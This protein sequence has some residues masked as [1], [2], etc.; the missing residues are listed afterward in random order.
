MDSGINLI[1]E[2]F[3][4]ASEGIIISDKKGRIISANPTAERMFGYNTG[5]LENMLIEDLVPQS[6]RDHHHAHRSQY[7]HQ[8]KPRPMGIGMDLFGQKRDGNVFPIEISLSHFIQD[9]QPFVA[10]FINDIT[11]RKKQQEQLKQYANQLEEKVKERTQELEHLNLGLRK[12]VMDRRAAE[13]ALRK[14]QKLYELIARNFPNGAVNVVDKE[15]NI[16]FREGKGLKFDT[17][18]QGNYIE[19]IPPEDQDYIKNCLAEC[20]KGDQSTWEHHLDG[21]T[22]M[23]HA[24][25]I[26]FDQNISEQIL[27][28]EENITEIK[29]AEQETRKLL[30]RER[31]LNEMKSR[32]V[33]MASHEFRTPLSTVLS[34]VNLIAK[35]TESDQQEKRDK[36]LNRIR[37]SVKN[38]TEILNDF[39]SLEKLEAGAIEC[40]MEEVDMQAFTQEVI[41]D[42][43]GI[44]KTGQKFK[45][46][47]KGAV[48]FTTDPRLLKNV[49]IN[50]ISNAIKY[51]P[52]NSAV[53]IIQEISEDT[54]NIEIKDRGMG[55]PLEEQKDLFQRFFRAKNAFNIQ[56]TGLGL[57]IVD[58]YISLLSGEIKLESEEGK[59]TT[60]KILLPNGTKETTR[61]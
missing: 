40:L 19:L 8:P 48:I 37:A 57:H 52:E 24:V 42:L 31:E 14:S 61:H 39:L 36:H 17:D 38:L 16:L 13:L 33:S 53:D 4:A 58:K 11:E 27:I 43:S 18:E 60:I 10:S 7:F 9:N 41:D 35:Y 6:I 20:Q 44:K 34:S 28:V 12:E 25:P 2:V 22:F 26:S 15:F 3:L 32:F 45:F 54:L 49:L 47:H 51:S 29:K 5:E 23:V 59:G 30:S 46:D 55:I 21:E 1:N 56:G 50:L